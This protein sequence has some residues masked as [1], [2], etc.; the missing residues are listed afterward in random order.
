MKKYE[1]MNDFNSEEEKPQKR[2]RMTLNPFENL[3]RKDGKG[4]E[5]GEELNVLDKPGLVNFFKLLRRKL[6]YIFSVN[7]LAVVGNF[8]LLFALFALAYTTE[9]ASSPSY[10]VYAAL[11]GSA[12]FDASP[13]V[14]SLLGAFGGQATVTVPT[15]ATYV[16]I[17]LSALVL[18]TFG[19][20][21]VGNTYI[22]RNVV[23]G[24][25]VFVWNDFWYAIRKNLKQ[26]L[27]FGAVDVAIIGML[28]YDVAA[29]RANAARGTLYLWLYF[30]SYCMVVLYFFVRMYVYPMM[31]T[32]DM[33]IFKL[34]KNGVLF[35]VL[36]IKRN[37]MV[38]LGTA[39][40]VLIDIALIRVFMP[41]G[42]ILPFIILFGL[43]QFM[44]VYGAYPK[45]KEIMIDP[46]YK[47]VPVN[48]DGAGD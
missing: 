11:K 25:P 5:K 41:I 19:P 17:A 7:I 30:F 22:L 29:Y 23:R 48:E 10:Q 42:I 1:N 46:Y 33:S 44:T 28:A 20:V 34:L 26:A 21:N 12:M 16:L 36:G 37:M 13:V 39:A 6:N 2:K 15:A 3:Y 32:F 47:E 31:V 38:L 27:I 43:I 8:P 24:E 9:S 40:A 35:S 14:T 18:F 4:V 45:I